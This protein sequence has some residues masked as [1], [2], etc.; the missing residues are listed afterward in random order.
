[1]DFRSLDFEVGP[2]SNRSSFSSDIDNRFG[3]Q[4]DLDSF[5]L[6]FFEQGLA[7]DDADFSLGPLGINFK[8]LTA[9]VVFSDNKNFTHSNEEVGVLGVANI[10]FNVIFQP[11]DNFHILL[12]GDLVVLPFEKKI[13]INGLG[14]QDPVSASLGMTGGSRNI[15]QMQLFYNFTAGDWDIEFVEDFSVQFGGGSSFLTNFHADGVLYAWDPLV[16]DQLDSAGRYQFTSEG[17]SKGDRASRFDVD[18]RTATSNFED[19]I[20]IST[21][22]LGNTIGYTLPLET[23]FKLS[24]YRQDRW[25][26]QNGQTS[27]DATIGGRLQLSNRRKNLRFKPF[28]H[29][30]YILEPNFSSGWKIGLK[31]DI[32]ENMVAITDFGQTDRNDTWRLSLRHQFNSTT[33][34]AL[35]YRKEV[36]LFDVR[37]SWDYRISKVLGHKFT[38]DF[39]IQGSDSESLD[40]GEETDQY[41]YGLSLRKVFNKD[42]RWTGT[43]GYKDI[44]DQKDVKDNLA[45]IENRLHINTWDKYRFVISHRWRF[46]NPGGTPGN[47]D[48][49]V[50][51]FQLNRDL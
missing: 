4:I 39:I 15:S 24:T 3:P 5:G 16:F 20:T 35:S 17:T 36:Y 44:I 18:N 32:T 2:T 28:A 34:H 22:T 11:L 42:L 49:N 30:K 45:D 6:P 10:G 43:I 37:Q 47:A 27:H 50:I 38:T 14:M 31:S 9:S 13:G 33:L 21:N 1:M 23:D 26:S 29:Y 8:R 41:F 19:P 25:F 51:I 48:E 7:I 40:T 12:R 46:S